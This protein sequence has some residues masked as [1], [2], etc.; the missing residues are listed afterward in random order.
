GKVNTPE[1]AISAPLMNKDECYGVLVIDS[2]SKK[3]GFTRENLK[4][5]QTFADQ[6]LIAIDN[7]TLISQN[8]RA[9]DIHQAL[10]NVYM[11]Q[12]GLKEITKTLANLIDKEFCVCND[13]LDILSYTSE[14]IKK[15]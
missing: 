9:N 13:F 2:F 15:L 1:S 4:L 3:D 5:L 10:T 6:A 11:S 12:K 8:E 14:K 7:A